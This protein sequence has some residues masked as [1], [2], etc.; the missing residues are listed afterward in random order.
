M[1]RS[2]ASL[3]TIALAALA[4]VA[5]GK[6]SD[7][8]DHRHDE[9]GGHTEAE[10]GHGDDHGD[11]H[12]PDEHAG[13][14]AE[15]EAEPGAEHHDMVRIDE[16]TAAELG[17]KIGTVGPGTVRDAHEVQG[18]L[19]PIEGKHA[20]V[21][22]RYPGPVQSVKIGVGDVVK[23]G[24]TLA[25]IESNVSLTPYAVTAPFAGTVLDVSA[26]PG[27]LAGEEPLFEIADL[28]S[29]WV[30]LH[31]FG[32]DAQHIT[33]GLS[34]EVTRLSDGARIST[35]LDRVLP[36]TATASQSTVAR[37]TIKNTD[38]QWRPGA[39]VRA[40]VTVKE[41]QASLVVPVSALQTFEGESVVFVRKGDTYAPRAV[42]LGEK[43]S[44]NAE[45]LEGLAAGE[46]IVVEQSYLIKADLE[47][48]SAGHEH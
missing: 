4:L 3:V 15:G 11:D 29:L 37:A 12:G 33:R 30:D 40:L 25:V 26:G 47:K 5:C 24:E 39:A 1:S 36:G 34:V 46:E 41:R 21:R 28:T 18:L 43:D 20:R 16:K 42:K 38:G 45:V 27:D 48:E 35:K 22:A 9:D 7:K 23:A 31:L 19:T 14:H 8:E 32:G 17:V 44:H 6:H 13:E 2:S 10:H